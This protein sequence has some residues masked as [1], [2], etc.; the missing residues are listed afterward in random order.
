MTG[1]EDLEAQLLRRLAV[2]LV[3]GDD[4][5][6]GAAEQHARDDVGDPVLPRREGRI[7]RRERAFHV[8]KVV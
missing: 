1:L 6:E 7:Q 2:P 8:S 4:E 3:G 5:A